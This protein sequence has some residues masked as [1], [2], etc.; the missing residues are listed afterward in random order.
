MHIFGPDTYVNMHIYVCIYAR[1]AFSQDSKSGRPDF[2]KRAC[3]NEQFMRQHI[4]HKTI[5]FKVAQNSFLIS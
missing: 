4:K 5:P 2:I 3:S 1:H